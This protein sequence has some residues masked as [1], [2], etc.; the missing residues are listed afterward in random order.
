[1]ISAI[2]NKDYFKYNDAYSLYT[3]ITDDHLQRGYFVLLGYN[4]INT[5]TFDGFMPTANSQVF[6]NKKRK[7]D[8][9][10]VI[11]NNRIEHISYDLDNYLSEIYYISP[12]DAKMLSLI[13][14]NKIN[15]N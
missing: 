5:K 8:L 2:Y 4:T 14:S 15:Y 6:I 1:Y 13:L 11:N 12:A 10:C 7:S 3:A 9:G